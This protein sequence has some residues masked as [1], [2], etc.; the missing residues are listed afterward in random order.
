MTSFG[1]SGPGDP[2]VFQAHSLTQS[3]SLSPTL[4]LFTRALELG[5]GELL[6]E[7]VRVRALSSMSRVTITKGSIGGGVV[8]AVS[9]DK[10]IFGVL[11]PSQPVAVVVNALESL[12]KCPKN[13]PI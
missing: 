8:H 11:G 5:T 12:M 7:C 3:H 6:R 10:F 9:L 1:H 2:I 13:G 4:S